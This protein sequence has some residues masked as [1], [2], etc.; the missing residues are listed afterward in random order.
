MLPVE[1]RER[2]LSTGIGSGRHHIGNLPLRFVLISGDEDGP[3]LVAGL[4]NQAKDVGSAA[5]FLS[6]ALM[7]LTWVLI[8]WERFTR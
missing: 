3:S 4:A 6:L 1:S 5:V 7:L 8:G 2:I